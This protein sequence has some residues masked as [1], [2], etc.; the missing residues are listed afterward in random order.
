MSDKMAA[1]IARVLLVVTVAL[2]AACHRDAPALPTG[3][4]PSTPAEAEAMKRSGSRWSN[5]EIRALYLSKARAIADEDTRER[6]AGVPILERARRAFAAR[7]EARL[8]C[9][10]MMA[11]RSEEQ[12]LE[13]RD[14]A[15]Y[16]HPD[17][18]T[19]DE[20]VA[21]ERSK[22]RGGDDA[23]QA[24]IESSQRTDSAVNGAFGL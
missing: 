6:A 21:H 4:L 7:H 1:W 22:G 8:L 20:L 10:A 3:P 12:L 13:R 16:G 23:F 19:F 5:G 17:G 14:Q 9:R 24:I 15:K 18:P 2:G 11:D